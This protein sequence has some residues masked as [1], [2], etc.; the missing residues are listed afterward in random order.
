VGAHLKKASLAGIII[1]LGIVFGDIG[2][3]PL[4]T[5]NAIVRD[6]TISDLLVIGAVSCVIWTLT[7]QTTIKYVIL[8]LRADNNG[9]GGIFSLF[10]LVRRHAKWIVF[11]A[12]IGGAALLAD[13]LITPPITVTSAIEGLDLQS[14]RTNMI[15]VLV[16]IAGIFFMQQFGTQS[17]GKL[18]GP[19]MVLWFIMMAVTGTM[20]LGDNPHI[21]SAFNPYWAIKLLTQY[22]QG[23]WLLG[24]VFLCTTGA[25][26][27]YS[28]L[29]HVGKG[30]IRASW[31]FVKTCL[32][33]NYIGQGSWLL[34]HH[35]GGILHNDVN[36]FF[37][38]I[39]EGPWRIAAII[40]ATLAAII[41]SQALI[42]GSFTLVN[43][44]IKLNLWPKMKINFPTTEKG[45]LFI[46]GINFMLWLGCT[47]VVIFFQASSAAMEGAYG[48]SI[49]ITMIMTSLLL[50]FYL[51]TLRV[52]RI[53]IGLYLAVYLSI[54]F[55]F[56]IAN[57]SKFPPPHNGFVTVFIAGGIFSIMFMWYRARKI[58]NRYVEFVRLEDYVPIIQ[59][60]SN[61]RTIPKYATHLVY[62]TSANFNKEIEHKIIFSILYKK[63][64]RA[65]IYWF[66]HVDVVDEPYTMEY[67]VQTVIP[68]EIIRIEFRLGFRVEHKIQM[69][70][71]K[72][73]EE[74]VANKE[75][76][77]TSRY[78]SLS[79]NNVRGDFRFI[80]LEKF[81]S[82]DNALPI[83]DKIIM[84][85]YFIL[86]KLS[87]SEERSF[88]LDMSDVT[89]EKFPLIVSKTNDIK[90]QRVGE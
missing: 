23:F 85:G 66:V 19:I 38:L 46:P 52:P 16:I 30:N 61:D 37:A 73:V 67:V 63:P 86:K 49:T 36:I 41:A 8:T 48:L 54:E 55:S 62:M 21:F 84:R 45:Q 27:L 28:D 39:P 82:R 70:F 60:L 12:M 13:G 2:T 6:K 80:V 40:I 20:H 64:K 75:V 11:F 88:G 72:V 17:I 31:I 35:K 10:A 77:V 33:L 29:G 58:K 4:Y 81:L 34:S 90:L 42:S 7:L 83:F 78:E 71:K 43:E 51:F 44:A 14:E 50:S 5:M 47:A 15:V 9:E 69:M 24:S 53:W 26:A 25:E 32:I 89:T 56:L 1:A 76:N 68:N 74:M 18:F 79:K 57:L 22:P 87:L 59:E 65:D 3:S